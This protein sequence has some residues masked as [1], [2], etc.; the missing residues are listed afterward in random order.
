MF[1]EKDGSLE[2]A[3]GEKEIIS[4]RQELPKAYHRDG[5]IYLTKAEVILKQDSLYGNK[6]GFIENEDPFYVNL[7]TPSDWDRAERILKN[8]S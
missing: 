6:I 4:R 3:T 2:I 8:R 5:A 7:D 1:E